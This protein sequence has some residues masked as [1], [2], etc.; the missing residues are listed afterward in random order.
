LALY[1]CQSWWV[2]ASA[3]S[4]TGRITRLASRQV[5]KLLIAFLPHL[6]DHRLRLARTLDDDVI[7][8]RTP[9]TSRLPGTP[10]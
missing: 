8:L 4:A 2:K 6:K 10:W 5:H 1:C 9:L 7:A 3:E